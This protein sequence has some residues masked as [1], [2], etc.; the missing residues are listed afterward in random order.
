MHLDLVWNFK[1]MLLEHWII[2]NSV[3][4]S[5]KEFQSYYACC[6]INKVMTTEN[7]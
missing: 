7:G 4:S 5:V 3:E 1:V 6:E 2:S